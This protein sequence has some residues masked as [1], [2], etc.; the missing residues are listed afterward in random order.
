M[1]FCHLAGG[2]F[3]LGQFGRCVSQAANAT[4]KT[5]TAWPGKLSGSHTHNTAP[6]PKAA[7]L[8]QEESPPDFNR[9]YSRVIK[10]RKAHPPT[11][12]PGGGGGDTHKK[13]EYNTK[14]SK[15]CKCGPDQTLP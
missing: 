10:R 15:P 8:P 6:T 14:D 3:R 5:G 9:G 13:A 2:A 7:S 11:N 4:R 1:S 12:A